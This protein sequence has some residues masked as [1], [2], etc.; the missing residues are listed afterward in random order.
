MLLL[1]I[2][3]YCNINN[4]VHVSSSISI[5]VSIFRRRMISRYR[6]D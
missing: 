2:Q 1:R 6:S 5:R 3:T 4:R